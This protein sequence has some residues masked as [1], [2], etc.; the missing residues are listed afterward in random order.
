MCRLVDCAPQRINMLGRTGREAVW[1]GSELILKKH[2]PSQGRGA[3]LP[4]AVVR[5]AASNKTRLT[6]SSPRP[7]WSC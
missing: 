3:S 2:S 7:S 6:S 4:C 5:R 1:P